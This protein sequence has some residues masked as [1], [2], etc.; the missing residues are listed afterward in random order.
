MML[1]GIISI[2][3]LAFFQYDIRRRA[4]QQNDKREALRERHN[5]RMQELKNKKTE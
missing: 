3:V 5:R 1:I 4:K 2:F